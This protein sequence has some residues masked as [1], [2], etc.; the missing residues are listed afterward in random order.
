RRELLQRLLY[1]LLSVTAGDFL[2]RRDRRRVLDQVAAGGGTRVRVI[3]CGGVER[4][5]EALLL[6]AT[7]MVDQQVAGDGGHPGGE[8]AF[9]GVI[10]FQGP[11]QIGRAH[12]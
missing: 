2:V 5:G 12:V 7:E 10:G 3:G 8:S 4:V 11:I 6:G 1:Q 9:T